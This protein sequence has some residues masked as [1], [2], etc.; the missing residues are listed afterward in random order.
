MTTPV[1]QMVLVVW[2]DA[3]QLDGGPW[4]D[5]AEHVY[6]PKLFRQVGFLLHQSDEGVILSHAWSPDTVATRDQIPA[7]MIRQITVLTT[8]TKRPRKSPWLQPK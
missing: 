8:G 1:P 2:E 7:G 5:N 6:A 3:T 4:A